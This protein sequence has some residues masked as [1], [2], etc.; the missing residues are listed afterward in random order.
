MPRKRKDSLE[1][2]PFF[3]K[4]MMRLSQLPPAELERIAA[5]GLE[6]IKEENEKLDD[7]R[8]RIRTE[9]IGKIRVVRRENQNEE[10]K[11]D[12]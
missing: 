1:N 5:K 9:R 2:Q 10:E 8:R 6:Y 7:R 12:C 11:K 3:K 4:L